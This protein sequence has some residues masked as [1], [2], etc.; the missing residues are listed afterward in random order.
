MRLAALL[1]LATLSWG[2]TPAAAQP[3]AAAPAVRQD[4]GYAAFERAVADAK[5]AMMADPD[6]ALAK[7]DAALARARSLAP[8]SE[9]EKAIATA[10]WLKGEALLYSNQPEMAKPVIDTALARTSRVAPGSKLQGDLLRSHGAI[11]WMA[12]RFQTA[13]QAYQRAYDIFDRAKE[14]RSQAIALQDIALIYM[15]AGDYERVLQYHEQAGELYTADPAFTLTTHNNRGEVLRKLGRIREA[16]TQFELALQNARALKSP[17]L[18]VRILS[19]LA[20]AQ[21]QRGERAKAERTIARAL[22]LTGSGQAMGWKGTVF[23]VAA[24]VAAARGDLHGAA[25]YLEQAFAGQDLT[26][27]TSE[28]REIHQLAASV[29]ERLG[30]SGKAL[31]HLKAFQRLEGEAQ[32][33]TSSAS[34]QLM[35]AQFDYQN[36]QQKILQRDARIQRQQAQF[37]TGLVVAAG[38]IL[39]LLLVSALRIRRSRNQVRAANV[40][41]NQT[42]GALEKALKAKTEFLATTSHEIRTPLNGILGMTQILLANRRLEREVREQVQVVHGAG[43]AMKSLVDDIL[44]VAKMETGEVAVAAEEVR[45]R[46]LLEDAAR[47]WS[48]HA[49][50]KGL[51]LDI[52]I[53]GAPGRIVSDEARLRQIVSNLLS[54]AIKFTLEGSVG[55]GAAV[56][57]EVLVIEVR[58]TGIGI[59][60]DQQQ[61]VFEAF[62]QVDGGTTRQFSG[63]GLG[64]SI[65]R[66]LAEALGGSIAVASQ[67]GVG[68]RFTVRLPLVRVEE[69]EAEA[70]AS[71]VR[72][73]ALAGARM[74]LVEGNAMKQGAIR[75]LLEPVTQSVDCV[76]NGAMAIAALGTGA[77]DH[78]LVEAASGGIEDVPPLEALRAVIEAA[79]AKDVP[80]TV[81]LAPS[82][83][84]PLGEVMQLAPTRLILKPV[85]GA[86]L[87]AT[88]QDVYNDIEM[89]APPLSS[90]A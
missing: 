40:V 1:A 28:F 44:D 90:A 8:S 20:I 84:L 66:N 4:P 81:L 11:E 10:E 67:M 49:Q 70:P 47:L 48:G 73:T 54:N 39:V 72:P 51:A 62:H 34:A 69:T 36:Q 50:G 22:Q 59:P 16:E 29:Y 3:K 27:T 24:E 57:G 9:G 42:N 37:L 33:L 76:E 31:Q 86:Q 52:D 32:K 80:V 35:S 56:D 65:C 5:Q 87:I 14:T 74:L 53:A 21:V 30:E 2:N 85:G 88:L 89:G 19:N 61:L 12:G 60:E 78:L 68:T 77:V 6:Q 17:M 82:E 46:A 13:L 71:G 64:L 26:K 25:R 41:L 58:D 7:A 38:I 45:F 15:D 55:L 63:T 79:A 43:E 23:G 75:A 18:E 83:A